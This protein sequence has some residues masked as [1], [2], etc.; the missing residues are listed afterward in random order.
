MSDD[1]V[2]IPKRAVLKAA[3]VCEI[4]HV[5][6]YVLRTWETEFPDLGAARASG[7]SRYYRRSDVERVLHI[8]QLLFEEGL[9]LAGVRRRLSEEPR[10][11]ED[12]PPSIEELLGHDARE[13]LTRVRDALKSIQRLL[14]GNGE[15]ENAGGLEPARPV[16]ARST[17]GGARSS[18][19]K[20][21]RRGKGQPKRKR[22]RA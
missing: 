14:S 12:A 5:Q 15:P 7:G 16:K 18:R 4:A 20:T 22:V 11:N 1:P 21:G 19:A 3:E 8:K 9:T 13:R 2:D 17:R 6:P 10:P